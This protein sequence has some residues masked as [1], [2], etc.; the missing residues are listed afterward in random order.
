VSAADLHLLVE[1]EGEGEEK[2]GQ[3]AKDEST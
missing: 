3:Y 1:H 2:L